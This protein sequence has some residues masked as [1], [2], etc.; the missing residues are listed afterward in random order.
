MFGNGRARSGIVVLPC[1]AGK[2]LTGVTA[3][4]T[5]KKSTVILCINN[6]SVKQWKDQLLQWTTIPVRILSPRAS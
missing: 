4:S 2:S 1:G 6:V 5:V 3:A